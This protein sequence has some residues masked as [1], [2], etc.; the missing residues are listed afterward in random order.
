MTHPAVTT[1][2]TSAL[3]STETVDRI[4]YSRTSSHPVSD[5]VI[6]EEPLTVSIAN[7]E[8]RHRT[9]T[10]TMR[11]PGDDVSLV[12]GFL[13][14]EG[15]IQSFKDI[16]VI[17]D[18]ENNQINLQLAN[19]TFNL[20]HLD[21]KHF[22]TH[23]SCGV[24]GQTNIRQLELKNPPTIDTDNHWLS[25]EMLLALPEKLRPQQFV[26][27]QTGSS[28]GCAL[29]DEQGK[30]T[31]LKE[32]VG[33]HN[34]LDKL[35]GELLIQRKLI[36]D[37]QKSILLLSGRV[38]FELVQKAVMAGIPV[39]AAIGAPSSLAIDVAKRFGITL[40][41]FLS[42]DAFNVYNGHWRLLAGGE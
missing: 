14:A 41:G 1:E 40:I 21:I 16:E 5:S 7:N 34:A 19:N 22:L 25:P 37:T 35:I 18:S 31:L 8:T 28:H 10:V 24:C 38:S 6:K 4:R 11:T 30:I 33:R 27:Q 17:D 42:D 20:D 13:F 26:F 29:F 15:I 12:T 32:D 3:L 2:P 23:S 9:L 36:T 39:I